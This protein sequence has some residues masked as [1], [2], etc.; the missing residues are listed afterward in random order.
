MHPGWKKPLMA[1]R[2]LL[3]MAITFYAGFLYGAIR[4][5]LIYDSA[6]E[7]VRTV[8]LQDGPKAASVPEPVFT[9][10]VLDNK[11]VPTMRAA[12]ARKIFGPRRHPAQ[13]TLTDLDNATFA[14]K[15]TGAPAFDTYYRQLFADRRIQVSQIHGVFEEIEGYQWTSILL[16]QRAEPAEGLF[17]YYHGHDGNPLAFAPPN[18]VIRAMLERGYDVAIFC[19]PGRGWNGMGKVRVKTWDGW[20]YLPEGRNERHAL[21]TMIDT[22]DSHFIKFFL[23][24]VVASI[25]LATAQRPYAKIVMAGHSGGGWATTIAAALDERIDISVSYAGTLPFFARHRPRDL[26]DE[27]QM[28]PEFYRDFPYP[29]LYELASASGEKRRVHYQLFNSEDACCFDSDSAATFR[30][31]LEARPFHPER[32]LRIA[33]LRNKGHHMAADAVLEII[34]RSEATEARR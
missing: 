20:V 10:V 34:G 8:D 11:A 3:L 9:P 15:F 18:I 19:M 33:I 22:G 1:A 17:V 26:G 5:R 7:G 31:Y 30:R 29:L 13:P 12:L 4:D 23:E 32:D 2:V 24:P 27:E 14:S 21:F 25:D 6:A 28:N 16:R